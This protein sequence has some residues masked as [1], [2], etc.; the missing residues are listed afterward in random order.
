MTE[1]CRVRWRMWYGRECLDLS[2]PD[3]WEVRVRGMADGP[4]MS[5]EQ[6]EAAVSAPV[7]T[8]PLEELARG[9]SDCCILVDDLTRPTPARRVLPPLLE[10]LGRVG[11]GEREVFFVVAGGAHGPVKR[12]GLEK[13]LGPRLCDRYRVMRHD[14]HQNLTRVPNV[15]CLGEMLLNEFFAGAD[16]KLAVTGVMPHFM[17]GF[18]GGAKIVMPGS[19][20]LE[21]IARTHQHTVEGLPARVGVVEGNRMR[22]II[23]ESARRAGL[24]FCLNAL[25][26]SA[27]ELAGLT[28][29]EPEAA[30]RAA[31][32]Q[33]RRI[34]ATEA[35]R[36]ADVG[37]FNAFPKDTEFIQTMAA[38]NVWSD[39]SGQQEA[40]VRPAGS[41]V[42]ISACPEGLGAHELIEFGRRQ[43]KRRDRHGSFK[44]IL[45][46]RRLLFLAP[47]VAPA[48]VERYYGPAARH[49]ATWP[50]LRNELQE[51]HAEG[52]RV[53]VYPSAALQIDAAALP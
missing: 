33:A 35:G 20:G 30:H 8:P 3:G 23:E 27:G 11:L 25:F 6:I 19:C 44:E 37:V 26:N 16:L 49:F 41:I 45:G 28:C 17:C 32:R 29:G 24:D 4:G 21:T 40:L 51:L 18:S 1:S 5:D 15:P 42:V 7:G 52:A 48:T 36:G 47:G 39:R 31:A 12:A 13:K 2:W 10:A 50:S 53:D 38:L 34:Y 43:F 14:T 9:C 46:G 22:G